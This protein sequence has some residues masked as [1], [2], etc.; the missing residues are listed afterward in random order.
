MLN[1]DSA[2]DDSVVNSNLV[3]ELQRACLHGE[4][5]G[6]R[7]WF[8]GFVDDSDLD[9]ELRQPE[10]EHEAG[11]SGAGDKDKVVG[12][13][14]R[15]LLDLDVFELRIDTR[16]TKIEGLEGVGDL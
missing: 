9:A 14:R 12:H 4:R 13:L 16:I 2:R 7:A 10:R 6:R 5:A 15:R 3:I 1:L 8:R 11:R